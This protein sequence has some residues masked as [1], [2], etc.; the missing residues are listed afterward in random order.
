MR[1]FTDPGQGGRLQLCRHPISAWLSLPAPERP[2]LPP[3]PNP[4]LGQIWRCRGGKGLGSKSGGHPGC[5]LSPPT[6]RRGRK[7]EGRAGL[8]WTPWAPDRPWLPNLS[9]S[10]FCFQKSPVVTRQENRVALSSAGSMGS[11]AE[12]EAPDQA[13]SCPQTELKGP[14]GL[15][16]GP[17]FRISTCLSSSSQGQGV[18]VR[19]QPG[20]W[21]CVCV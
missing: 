6:L 14:R 20:L 17:F 19:R 8:D 2:F 7:E 3:S 4:L 10:S 11:P 15:C 9:F 5:T 16:A 1:P 18:Q 12:T 21:G 13:C